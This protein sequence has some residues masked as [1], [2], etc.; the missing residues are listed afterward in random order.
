MIRGMFKNRRVYCLKL[1]LPIKNVTYTLK[2][3]RFYDKKVLSADNYSHLHLSF[4]GFERTFYYVL[5]GHCCFSSLTGKISAQSA[6]A[7]IARWAK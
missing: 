4:L 6:P 2:Q 1:L 5:I 3:R 7:H